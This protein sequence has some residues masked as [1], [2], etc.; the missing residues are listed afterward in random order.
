MGSKGA[1]Y[2]GYCVDGGIL[3]D[4]VTMESLLMV[5]AYKNHPEFWKHAT[6]DPKS[7]ALLKQTSETVQTL[8]RYFLHV[9][10]AD[11]DQKDA[12]DWSQ[13]YKPPVT[14]EEKLLA[15][16]AGPKVEQE[17]S[18]QLKPELFVLDKHGDLVDI[19]YNTHVMTR[20]IQSAYLR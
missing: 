15:K 8:V 5:A 7:T 16:K 19:V 6:M 20:L 13:P 11:A 9:R 3:A 12:K 18:P 17:L 2:L 10:Q 1:G 14:D 4:Y